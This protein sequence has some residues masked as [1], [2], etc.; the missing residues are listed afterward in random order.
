MIG[1]TPNLCIYTSTAAAARAIESCPC[2]AVAQT[3]TPG[4]LQVT[5]SVAKRGEERLGPGGKAGQSAVVEGTEGRGQGVRQVIV[6]NHHRE[7]EPD[8]NVTNKGL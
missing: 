7:V 1:K 8:G 5:S 2:C 4:R 3:D 6:H